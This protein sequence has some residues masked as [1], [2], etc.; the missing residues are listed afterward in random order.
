MQTKEYNFKHALS[1]NFTHT[2]HATSFCKIN[3]KNVDEK[4]ILKDESCMFLSRRRRLNYDISHSKIAKILEIPK[5]TF[6]RHLIKCCFEKFHVIINLKY[7]RFI[8]YLHGQI[9][10]FSSS[11]EFDEINSGRQYEYSLQFS[12]S[13]LLWDKKVLTKQR[14]ST[15][16]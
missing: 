6:V 4:I 15:E 13:Y 12:N 3:Y 14:K 16:Y 5:S 8:L 2:L 1:H 7:C 10:A 11:N 9:K